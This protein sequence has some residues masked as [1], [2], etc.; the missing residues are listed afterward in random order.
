MAGEINGKYSDLI[1]RPINYMTRGVDRPILAALMRISTIGLVTPL[2]DGMNLV[3][4][5]YVSAQNR[6]DPGVLVLSKFAGAAEELHDTVLVNPF[7]PADIARGIKEG[8]NMPL[9]QRIEL[10]QHLRGIVEANTVHH[11]SD[12]YLSALEECPKRQP[13]LAL[14]VG[15]S[16]TRKAIPLAAYR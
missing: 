3:A 9:E 15:H 10:N 13:T 4:K 8:I 16:I 11:W 5:E 14:P 1:Y 6:E 2:A 12:K 7:D